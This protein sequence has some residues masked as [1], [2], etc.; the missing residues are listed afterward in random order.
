MVAPSGR[1]SKAISSA[2]LVPSRERALA[3]LGL[4]LRFGSGLRRRRC[5]PLGQLRPPGLGVESAVEYAGCGSE[6]RLGGQAEALGAAAD[7]LEGDLSARR[8][9]AG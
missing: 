3:G 2:S 9:R 7:R 6:H 1:R 4:A 8:L 5:W